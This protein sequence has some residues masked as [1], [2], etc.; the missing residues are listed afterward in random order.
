MKKLTLLVISLAMLLVFAGCAKKEET[1]AKEETVVT[2]VPVEVQGNYA[3]DVAG[4][5]MLVVSENNIVCDWSSSAATRSHFEIPV[6]YDAETNTIKYDAA[7]L[8]EQ[9]FN[10]QGEIANSEEKYN[11][12]TGYFEIV[13]NKLI[14]HDDMSEDKETTTFV[15]Y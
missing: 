3:D 7:V 1:P 6:V 9:T 4:R 12:G 13:E 5:A 10:E 15:K 2:T 14:W 8:T 11:N